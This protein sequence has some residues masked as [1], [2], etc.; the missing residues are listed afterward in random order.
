M[1]QCP[2]SG[3]SDPFPSPPEDRALETGA[4]GSAHT[5]A[6]SSVRRGGAKVRSGAERARAHH[7]DPQ[8]AHSGP[9][10]RGADLRLVLTAGVGRGR[11]ERPRLGSPFCASACGLGWKGRISGTT[12]GGQENLTNPA[13]ICV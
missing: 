3:L 10:P 11:L 5:I 13:G 7:P 2:G 12:L 4:A 1:S 6:L 8:V 9:A